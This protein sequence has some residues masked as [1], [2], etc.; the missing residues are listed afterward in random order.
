MSEWFPS[1]WAALFASPD[2]R[3]IAHRYQSSRLALGIG[4]LVTVAWFIADLIVNDH[5][6]GDL[7]IIAGSMALT[8]IVAMVYY[9]V[10]E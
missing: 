3:F 6:R 8:K 5:V 1:I 9:R 2:E 10:T 4:M 7:A